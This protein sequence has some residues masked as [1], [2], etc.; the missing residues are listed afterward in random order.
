[1]STLIVSTP[2]MQAG[3]LRATLDALPAVQVVG[4]ASGCLSALYMVRELTPALLVIDSNLPTVDVQT[5]LKQ[6]QR[7]GLRTHSLVLTVTREQSR[8]ARA[9]GADATLPRDASA[10][11]LI[12]LLA[13]LNDLDGPTRTGVH[14]ASKEENT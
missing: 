8:S 7:E 14:L 13:G 4:S 3:S 2:G 9:A 5:L 10:E 1:M 12:A 6:I 11:Q